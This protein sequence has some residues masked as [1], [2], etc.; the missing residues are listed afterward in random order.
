MEG[1]CVP[2]TLGGA[3]NDRP[4]FCGD[5]GGNWP[6]VS[7]LPQLGECLSIRRAYLLTGRCMIAVCAHCR[8]PTGP[9]EDL[10]TLREGCA[11]TDH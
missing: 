10:I 11:R 1:M 8:L 6:A 4:L 2:L 3:E 7:P 9:G 5:G